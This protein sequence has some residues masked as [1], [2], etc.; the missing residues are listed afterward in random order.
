MKEDWIL[1]MTLDDNETEK[2]TKIFQNYID[3]N[4]TRWQLKNP[5]KER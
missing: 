5:K 3:R 4:Y 2:K 1:D